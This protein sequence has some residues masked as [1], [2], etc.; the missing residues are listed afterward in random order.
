MLR[1]APITGALP[2]DESLSWIL[3]RPRGRYKAAD[4]LVPARFVR[5]VWSAGALSRRRWQ[6]KGYERCERCSSLDVPVSFGPQIF[7]RLIESSPELA[8]LRYLP[9]RTPAY[10]N[11]SMA[12]PSALTGLSSWPAG[13]YLFTYFLIGALLFVFIMSLNPASA[14][15]VCDQVGFSQ[16]RNQPLNVFFN[17]FAVREL[18]FALIYLIFIRQGEWKAVSVVLAVQCLGGATDT[19]LGATKGGVGW[20]EAFK[21]HGIMTTVGSWAAYRIWMEN[22]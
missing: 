18:L 12:D 11:S 14:H 13:P 4:R 6:Y 5:T 19:Y 22:Q 8:Y 1:K 2:D 20:V 21:A 15:F 16:P 9:L 7:T 17:L 10:L 3:S